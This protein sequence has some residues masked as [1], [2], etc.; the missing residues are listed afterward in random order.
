M[1]ADKPEGIKHTPRR[2]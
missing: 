1:L 2:R